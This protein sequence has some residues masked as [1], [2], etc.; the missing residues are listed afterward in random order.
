[1]LYRDEPTS[2]LSPQ[3][4]IHFTVHRDRFLFLNNQPDALITQIYSVLKFY[5]RGLQRMARGAICRGP[6]AILKKITTN[7]IN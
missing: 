1:M 7:A 3:L 6:P 2:N 5:I 4:H